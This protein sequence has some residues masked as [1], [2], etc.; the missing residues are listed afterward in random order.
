MPQNVIGTVFKILIASLVLGFILKFLE[1]DPKDLLLNFGETI[2]SAF[3]WA[4]EFIAGSVEYVLI[5]AV[6]VVPIWLIVFLIGR[7]K[8][9]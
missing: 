1:I 2:Q 9:K 3:A 4:G 7:I 5:G 6:I 8:G